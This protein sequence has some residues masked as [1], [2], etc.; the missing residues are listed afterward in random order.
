MS[1]PR[2]GGD[3]AAAAAAAHRFVIMLNEIAAG[4]RPARA[5][6]PLLAT[7]LRGVIRQAPARPGPVADVHRLVVSPSV[8]GAYEI[9][10]VCRR[11]RRFDAV[12]LRLVRSGDAWRVTAVARP[13]HADDRTAHLSDPPGR[14]PPV[15]RGHR[16]DLGRCTDR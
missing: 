2:R 15:R 10:A 4:V 14:R 8:E 7:H 11:G 3:R 13:H 16:Y 1:A 5:V 6:F 12:G 9:V